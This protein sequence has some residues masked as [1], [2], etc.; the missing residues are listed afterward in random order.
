MTSKTITQKAHLLQHLASVREQ[1]IAFDLGE[2]VDGVVCVAAPVFDPH[3]RIVAGL[4]VS[5]PTSRMEAKLMVIRDDV[6]TAGLKISRMLGPLAT[7]GAGASRL[8]SLPLEEPSVE[9]ASQ[10]ASPAAPPPKSIS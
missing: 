5:G 4:S 6:R 8:P 10:S 7:A 9:V 1:G 3:G 2:N